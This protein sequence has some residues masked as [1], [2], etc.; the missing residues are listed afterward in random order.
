MKET[1]QEAEIRQRMQPGVLTRDGYLGHDDRHI[2]DIV[3]AD[4]AELERLG[5]TAE[6]L[7]TRMEHLM[8]TAFDS[9][10]DVVLVDGNWE[11]EY[12]SFRG[13]IVCAFMHPGRYRKG[14]IR[15]KNRTNGK[16]VEFTPLSV[17]LVREHH[18]FEGRGS[19]HRLEPA[20]LAETIL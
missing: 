20:H 18:F 3:A 5:I 16:Q 10:E 7:A 14:V 2:H 1:P 19:R 4:E 8:N 9:I 6:Q 11:V 17:H 13:F 15:V 12:E